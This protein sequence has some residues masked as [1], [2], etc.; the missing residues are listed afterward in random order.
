MKI[1][2]NRAFPCYF[3]DDRTSKRYLNS[4]CDVMCMT[5]VNKLGLIDIE[6]QPIGETRK[7]CES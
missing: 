5:T 4:V 1:A 3:S 6:E 7:S 2:I